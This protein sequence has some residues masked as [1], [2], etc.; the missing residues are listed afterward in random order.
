MMI[1]KRISIK[2]FARNPQVA[3]TASFVPVFQ[4]WIQEHTVEGLLIDVA[5]Y[6]HVPDGPGIILIGHEGDYAFNYSD[7]R[8]GFQYTRKIHLDTLAA[9]LHTVYRL[10]VAGA[11]KI[12]QER[13]LGGLSFDYSEARITLL[14]RL[15]TPNKLEIWESLQ[16]EIEVL[17]REIYGVAQVEI[18]R[19]SGDPRDCLTFDVHA[20][21]GVTPDIILERIGKPVSAV[22]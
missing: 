13:L 1:P 11:Q 4:R 3:D 5:D 2:F 18:S 9:T 15:Q 21:D 10:A 7:G 8:P 14:D 22:A 17:L 19:L 6:K 16:P 12:E 20:E